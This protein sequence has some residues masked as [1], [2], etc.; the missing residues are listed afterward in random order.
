MMV[1]GIWLLTKHKIVFCMHNLLA[2]GGNSTFGALDQ[3]G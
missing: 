2:F 3:H 1:V